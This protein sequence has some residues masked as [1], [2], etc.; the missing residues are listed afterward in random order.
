MKSRFVTLGCTGCHSSGSVT[1]PSWV[2]ETVGGLTLFQRVTARV[3]ATDPAASLIARCPSQGD[4]GMAQQGGFTNS[5]LTNYNEFLN[6]I[7]S[8]APNN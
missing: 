4:C 5:N 7:M 2:D 1:P 8:G 3:N 6:W